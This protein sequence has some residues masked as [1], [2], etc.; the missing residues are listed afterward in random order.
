VTA[1]PNALATQFGDMDIYVFDQLLRGRI[2]PGMTIIDAGCGS[3][4]NLV[5]LLRNGYDVS[6]VDEDA[7]A[8]D[9]AR[10]LADELAPRLA[11]DSFRVERIEEMTF[12]DARADVVISNAVL[13]FAR[14]EAHFSA[15]ICAMWRVLRP[16]G[17]LFCRLASTIGME[18][19]FRQI[20]GRRYRVPDGTERFLVD[21][22]MLMDT[23]RDLGGE[24]LDPLKTTVVQN[25]RCMTTWVVRKPAA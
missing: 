6:G 1:R 18:G 20:E 25:L 12:P 24:L 17:M 5:Y 11:P 9:A 23:T 14:D 7:K 4:R 21:E 3:G 16:G 22:R 19:R 2:T 8:I 13:H 15:M 10:R